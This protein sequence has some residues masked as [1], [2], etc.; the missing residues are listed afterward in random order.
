MS[1]T[2]IHA[3]ARWGHNIETQL[4]ESSFGVIC[5]TH[6]NQTSPWILFE[7][8][9]LAKS[10]DDTLVCPFLVDLDDTDLLPG[11]L[12]Q[13]QAKR[14]DKEGT[15][16]LVQSINR[17]AGSSALPAEKLSKAFERWWP[18][19]NKELASLPPDEKATTPGRSSNETVEEILIAVRE[20]TRRLPLE[21]LPSPEVLRAAV[22]AGKRGDVA[23]AAANVRLM[24][25]QVPD[26]ALVAPDFWEALVVSMRES[27][28]NAQA[29]AAVKVPDAPPSE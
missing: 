21:F 1:A 18:D 9:A 4:S 23:Q 16:E 5:L 20:L 29:A 22:A 6:E 8:G 3:G 10:I 24:L 27:Y 14:A 17:I 15:W 11:P 25:S 12:T 28:A 19:L 26:A 13:F 7:A 2:D